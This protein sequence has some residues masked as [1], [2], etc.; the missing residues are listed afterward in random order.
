MK[1]PKEAARE[2]LEG[3]RKDPDS[4]DPRDKKMLDLIE[5]Y[6]AKK[7]KYKDINNLGRND[8]CHCGSGKKFKKCCRS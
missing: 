5:K 1:N 6:I 8:P 7:I 4:L 3:L 2:M